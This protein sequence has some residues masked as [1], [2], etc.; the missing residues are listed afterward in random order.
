MADILR[1]ALEEGALGL[2][3]GLTYPP[4]M[5]ASTEELVELCSVLRELGGIYATHVRYT[6]GDGLLDG[7]REA[8]SIA[9]TSGCRL[10]ISHFYVPAAL[11]GKPDRMLALI[12]DARKSGVD[13][14]FDAY[15]YVYGS[16]TLASVLPGW[17]YEEGPES[18]LVNLSGDTVRNRIRAA[19]PPRCRPED[20]LIASVAAG[21]D[22]DC[23]GRI[24]TAVAE[25]RGLDAWDTI[26]D[27]L[28][29]NGLDVSFTVEAG[30]SDDIAAFIK[31]EAYMVGTDALFVDGHGNPRS[32][33]TF[34]NLLQTYVRNR[35]CLSL[36]D[37]VRKM[38]WLPA[39]RF[40]LV[41]R[42][43]LADN[44]KADIV[45]FDP[46]QIGTSSTLDCPDVRPSGSAP[47][48]PARTS[49]RR[50]QRCGRT[51]GRNRSG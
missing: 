23:E 22:K 20:I 46:L 21:E 42:G 28:Q 34:P 18:L 32:Y 45:V 3:T 25:S 13:V 41:G 2:S 50:G 7:F 30:D 17:A 44:A 4:G 14:T 48:G 37:A 43:Q 11:R 38:T 36:E 16:S 9:R 29:R 19:G 6:L 35:K 40:G 26:F 39:R 12:D 47:C 15:T 10:H 1:T 31:H 8:I 51:S 24:L 27:L 33:G 5:W 49:V